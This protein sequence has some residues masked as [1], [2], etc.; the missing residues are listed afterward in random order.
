MP[1]SYGDERGGQQCPPLLEKWQDRI[2]PALESQRDRIKEFDKNRQYSKGAQHR[3][4][5]KGLVTTNLIYVNQSTIIPHVYAKNPEIAVSPSKAIS[6]ERYAVVKNFARTME[7]VLQRMFVVDT[8]LKHRMRGALY[9]VM[10]TGE[11]WLKMIYQRDYESDPVIKTRIHDAQD[12]L[13]RLERL[14]RESRDEDSTLDAERRRDELKVMV[15]A[16]QK[17][18]EV[19]VSEGLVIDRVLSDDMLILDRTLIDFDG[20]AQSEALDQMIWMSKEEYEERFGKIASTGGPTMFHERKL[21]QRTAPVNKHEAVELVCVH[22]LWHLRS[23]TVYTFA[24][25]AK[26]WAREPYQPERMGERW[27]PFFRLGWNMLDGCAEGLPDVT[28]Q[29][30]LQDEYNSSR[31]QWSAT[32]RE[33]APVRVVRGNGSLTQDDVERIKNRKNNDIL[34]V[35]GKPGTPLQDDLGAIEG[36]RA[37]PA[38]YDTTPIRGDMEMVSGRGDASTGGIVEAKTATEAEM[39]QAGLASRSDYR[40][41]VTE[42]LIQ[43]MATCAAEMLLQELTVPQ[44]EFIAGQGSVWPMMA[45]N[46]VFALINI[47]IRAGSTG[48]PNQAKEREQWKE[49]LPVLQGT[50]TQ[51]FELQMAGNMQLASVMRSLLKET[52]RR[53]DER[54]DLEELLGPEDESGQATQI[55]MAQQQQTIIQLQ[56]QLEQAMAQLQ[57]VDQQKMQA[58]QQ[59][60]VDRQQD[61]TLKEREYQDRAE[62]RRM[63]REQAALEAQRKDSAQREQWDREDARSEADREFQREQAALQ[64]QFE[65]LRL[66]VEKLLP[67]AQAAS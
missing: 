54:M 36:M 47:E 1:E 9:S 63:S 33:A 14:I 24:E 51:I 41:D 64:A 25:G 10:N 19:V 4:G 60:A 46:E 56:Q 11:G 29:R 48:K 49:L 15:E 35:D 39:M 38:I 13:A 32:R 3:D 26:Y 6:P 59:A 8:R 58:E 23:N 44:V 45:K 7:V 21:D 57:Q 61:R 55:Q 17:Q 40:R 65:A 27:Y 53:Y 37:D 20:Y 16:M 62:E 2:K 5:E 28:L 52:L 67:L 66:Q 43:E 42:D 22:E 50:I 30:D 31:T 34:V 18:V 12:N